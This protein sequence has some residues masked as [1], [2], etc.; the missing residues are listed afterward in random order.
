[1][2][3]NFSM[4][5]II[6]MA[7]YVAFIFFFEGLYFE[8]E[9]NE[10]IEF[11]EQE[12]II[13]ILKIYTVEDDETFQNIKNAKFLYMEDADWHKFLEIP[14]ENRYARPE[15]TIEF[16][17]EVIEKKL[18]AS[19]TKPAGSSLTPHLRRKY[20]VVPLDIFIFVEEKEIITLEDVSGRGVRAQTGFVWSFFSKIHKWLTFDVRFEKTIVNETTGEK[21]TIGGIP[22]Y[23]Q[24]FMPV[25]RM[26]IMTPVW[27]FSALLL[28][29][30]LQVIKDLI[31]RWI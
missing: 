19:S 14:V 25:I 17:D 20:L 26:L 6:I 27:I 7:M 21:T 15:I 11:R 1:M 29:E 23:L 16:E 2:N 8:I 28:I 24:P 9:A 3:V 31:A 18:F 22:F 13:S 30:L 5:T 4:K 12:E 10:A